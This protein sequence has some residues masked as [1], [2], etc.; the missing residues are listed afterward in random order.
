MMEV[1]Y[2]LLPI[3]YFMSVCDARFPGI[4]VDSH[5]RII[6]AIATFFFDLCRCSINTQIGNNATG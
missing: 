5:L 4:M 3:G 6:I 1:Y 2:C